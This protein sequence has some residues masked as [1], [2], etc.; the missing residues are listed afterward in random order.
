MAGVPLTAEQLE[1]GLEESWDASE[2]E[3]TVD[4]VN[5]V[6]TLY[7]AEYTEPEASDDEAEEA[8]KKDYEKSP[9]YI[10]HL[11]IQ[12]ESVERKFWLSGKMMEQLSF[13]VKSQAFPVVLKLVKDG[14]GY[15]LLF[16]KELAPWARPETKAGSVDLT[17]AV[18]DSSEMP[19]AIDVGA[20]FSEA[21]LISDDDGAT[22]VGLLSDAGL[23]AIMDL[24][25][26]GKVFIK[27]EMAIGNRVKAVNLLNG[28]LEEFKKAQAAP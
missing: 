1:K 8:K 27:G 20:L 17:Q 16:I 25:Q 4:L 21:V 11:C 6:F 9:S 28:V 2:I 5:L 23:D 24:G 18:P 22:L 19:A 15:K 3:K 12:G 13:L 26:D 10:G 14:K 7:E